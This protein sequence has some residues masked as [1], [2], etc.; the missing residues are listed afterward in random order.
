MLHQQQKHHYHQQPSTTQ[1]TDKGG[2]S[3]GARIF[4]RYMFLVFQLTFFVSIQCH[5]TYVSPHCSTCSVKAVYFHNRTG[6]QHTSLH[7]DKSTSHSMK[8]RPSF[9]EEKKE[10]GNGRKCLIRKL[11]ITEKGTFFQPAKQPQVKVTNFSLWKLF[12]ILKAGLKRGRK[13]CRFLNVPDVKP[14]HF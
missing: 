6:I 14:E 8:R 3:S 4:S 12:P 13:E 10:Q 2:S 5:F 1:N 7:T 9:E 11:G